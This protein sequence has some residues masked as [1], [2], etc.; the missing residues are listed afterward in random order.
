VVSKLEVSWLP[1]NSGLTPL[2]LGI[3]GASVYG[4][5]FFLHM[6]VQKQGAIALSPVLHDLLS[7]GIDKNNLL[8]KLQHKIDHL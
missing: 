7:G 6:H 8:C 5:F 1:H 2:L 3:V 4:S